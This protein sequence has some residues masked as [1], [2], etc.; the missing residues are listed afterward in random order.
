MSK[1]LKEAFEIEKKE[2]NEVIVNDYDMFPDKALLDKLRTKII[3]NIIDKEV[4]KNKTLNSFIND[5]IDRSIE[6]YDLSNLQRS[7]IYNMIEDEINGN[8]PLSE[9]L[10]DKNITEIMVNGPKEIY[11]ERRKCIFYK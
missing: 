6:G 3:E 9:L 10:R 11:I 7:H 1:S 8:G 5:E 4:P 2:T